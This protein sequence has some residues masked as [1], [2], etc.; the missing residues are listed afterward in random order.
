MKIQDVNQSSLTSLHR[1]GCDR[2]PLHYACRTGNLSDVKLLV[3]QLKRPIDEY[4]AHDASPLYLAALC[5]FPDICKYLLEKGARC[6]PDSGG[7]A[8]RVF[9]VA[10]N[11]DMRKFLR[12][13]SLNAKMRDPFLDLIR[14]AFDS[15]HYNN[16]HRS[17][18]TRYSTDCYIEL[19]V[20]SSGGKVVYLHK[21]ILY[22]RCPQ[23]LKWLV[24]KNNS[25]PKDDIQ[26]KNTNN[27]MNS[28]FD[29]EPT[30]L[31]IPPSFQFDSMHD[32]NNFGN[33]MYSILQYLYI[34]TL[35]IISK[36]VDDAILVCKI[37]KYLK[38]KPL[39]TKIK[40]RIIKYESSKMKKIKGNGKGVLP[41]HHNEIESEF[42]C[43]ITDTDSLKADLKRRV[44]RIVCKPLED[45]S[46]VNEASLRGV[47]ALQFTDTIVIGPFG[48]KYLL[49]RFLLCAQSEYFEKALMGNFKESG[50][51][52]MDLSSLL[53]SNEALKLF[54]Q[55][56]Y[57]NEFLDIDPESFPSEYIDDNEKQSNSTD[58]IIEIG[59]L[60]VEFAH[61][62]FL[63][64][65][66]PY[67]TS[68]IFIPSVC[69]RNV[70]Q[71]WDL[72]KL[73]QLDRLEENCVEFMARNLEE[74]LLGGN[75]NNS[76]SD[77][78]YNNK[79]LF[80]QV[81][82]REISEIHQTGDTN[83]TDVPLIAEIRSVISRMP[84][85]LQEKLRKCR[86]LSDV[87]SEVVNSNSEV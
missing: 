76:E 27:N 35:E 45:W 19:N 44:A 85:L 55:W 36:N 2:Y 3:E 59:I 23:L 4:D 86:M 11:D 73:Y 54:I 1:F 50:D 32:N 26:S 15:Y 63:P 5:G 87:L 6:D 81:I 62:V 33:I 13:W 14:R 53:P 60:L 68:T 18:T 75:N 25:D 16:T 34:G 61:A 39:Y 71:F 48:R 10:L 29:M 20:G 21:I 65:L 46:G 30:Q 70:F 51:G 69:I 66:T 64:R 42:K 31:K 37:A 12:E 83:V 56:V 72:A 38:L 78:P 22:A 84:L 7:D 67:V 24:L 82:Q 41:S 8:A 40:K 49:N 77:Q 80:Q 79:E 57:C 47:E 28:Q 43:I 9:Y 58:D 52:V 74:I 17:N